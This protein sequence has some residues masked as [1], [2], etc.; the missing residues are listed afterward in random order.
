MKKNIFVALDFNSLD[1]AIDVTKKIKDYKSSPS[2]SR[3]AKSGIMMVFSNDVDVVYHTLYT[4]YTPH[5][6]IMPN[7]GEKG[8]WDWGCC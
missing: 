8:L 1:K 7:N 5:A 4:Q 2:R 3:T 6:K